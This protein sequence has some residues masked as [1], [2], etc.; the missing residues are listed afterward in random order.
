MLPR[1]LLTWRVQ[2]VAE[3]RNIGRVGSRTARSNWSLPR[4][5]EE[6]AAPCANINCHSS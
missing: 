6:Q 4:S 5:A 3:T 2:W 1:V